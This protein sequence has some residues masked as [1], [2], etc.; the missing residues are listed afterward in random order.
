MLSILSFRAQWVS[1]S[2][3]SS[4]TLYCMKLL[5]NDSLEGMCMKHT[6]AILNFQVTPFSN[7]S[8]R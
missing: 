7:P 6:G 5:I 2:P 4:Y 8:I 1:I 3:D